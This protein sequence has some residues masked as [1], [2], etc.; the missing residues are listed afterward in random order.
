[1]RKQ[2][3]KWISLLVAFSMFLSLL[4]TVAVAAEESEDNG[5][6]A[7][8]SQIIETSYSDLW[9]STDIVAKVGV[10]VKWY[11][12]VPEGTEPR[13]CG[14]TIK[15]PG[16]GWGTDT[17]N[18][19]EGHL[20]LVQGENFV[21]EF[22]PEETGDF[23]FT[24]WMGSGCH[25]NY[26]HITED[27]TYNGS[28]D[29]APVI[30]NIT[31]NEDTAEVSFDAPEVSGGAVITGYSLLAVSEDG[32]RAR[33]TG[34]ASPIT[35]TGLDKEK[36]YTITVTAKSTTGKSV[37][38][39]AVTVDATESKKEE[40]QIIEA[41]EV[42][43]YSEEYQNRTSSWAW[44][45]SAIHW[46]F[47]EG[48][49]VGKGD[50][51]FDPDNSITRAEAVTMLVNLQEI[52]TDA[53]N[54]DSE[55]F[56]DVNGA[57]YTRY[58]NAAYDKGFVAGKEEGRFDPNGTLT[59]AEAATIIVKALGY[60][61]VD[62]IDVAFQDISDAWYTDYVK[63]AYANGIVAGKS[64]ERFDP[65]ADV[66]RAEL[67]LMLYKTVMNHYEKGTYCAVAIPDSQESFTL[68]GGG[69]TILAFDAET[70]TVT[71]AVKIKRG[72]NY[73][74]VYF[75]GCD[76]FELVPAN[77]TLQAMRI[78]AA[79]SELAVYGSNI[80]KAEIAADRTVTVY[81]K[82]MIE[83]EEN[84]ASVSPETPVLIEDAE[85][86]RITW[87]QINDPSLQNTKTDNPFSIRTLES[88]TAFG[89]VRVEHKPTD[90]FKITPTGN[91]ISL[92]LYICL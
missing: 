23:L 38:S 44:S 4:P 69:K 68:T 39:E 59:R 66:T 45:H 19:E 80:A 2:F 60:K 35:V 31:R 10:P 84:L 9:N 43:R 63:T 29:S 67:A 88:G 62:E 89:G 20:T 72:E 70:K 64:A 56:S 32:V 90:F 52:D 15:I 34:E 46:A 75:D 11:V 83:S 16:L 21:Y 51:Y 33:A 7:E 73:Q 18:R 76:A 92:E 5:L 55:V 49:T 41:E 8:E 86:N 30:T 1:M 50:G 58:V 27:G 57:W 53:Y 85:G 48:I 3:S 22:T 36:S 40:T 79:G 25:Y 37:T 47:A 24:C 78:F 82:D 65:N 81:C 71:G 6:N 87:E 14:A 26:I 91:S 28:V 42:F 17:Y 77:G 74:L 13:G 12:N 61:T 54:L